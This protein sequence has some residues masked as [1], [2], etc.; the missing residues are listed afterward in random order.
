MKQIAL[1][2]VVNGR[3]HRLKIAPNL[4]LIDLLR[5]ELR[6][7]GTKEGCGVGECGAC[8]VVLDGEAVNAC[9]VLAGQCEGREVVTIE[10]LKRGGE[11]HPLQKA[12]IARGAVHCGFCTPGMIMS[13]HALLRKN[14]HPAPEEIARQIAGNLCRCTGYAQIVEAIRA[15]AEEISPEIRED[16]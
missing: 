5:D 12:F 2:L 6:L 10:G 9:L 7:T 13:A 1:S 11:L 3:K 16:S 4:R 14:P 8:T 15:A